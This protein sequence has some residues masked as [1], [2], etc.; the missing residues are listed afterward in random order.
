MIEQGTTVI[1]RTEVCQSMHKGVRVHA[2]THTHT[3]TWTHDRGRVEA[4]VHWQS[5]RPAWH[6]KC[7]RQSLYLQ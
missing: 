4:I 5:T 2:C 6:A 3:G 1:L 7:E